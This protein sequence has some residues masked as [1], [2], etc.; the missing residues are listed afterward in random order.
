MSLGFARA[1]RTASRG[2]EKRHGERVLCPGHSGVLPGERRVD[3]G[4]VDPHVTQEIEKRRG[5]GDKDPSP[6]PP[7]ATLGPREHLFSHS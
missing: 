1:F 6:R 5:P 7:H 2:E 3:P 4:T